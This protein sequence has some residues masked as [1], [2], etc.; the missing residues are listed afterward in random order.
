MGEKIVQQYGIAESGTNYAKFLIKK[1][2]E[3]VRINDRF[4]HRPHEEGKYPQNPFIYLICVKDIYSWMVSHANHGQQD[5]N[6]PDWNVTVAYMKE[7]GKAHLEW[8]EKLHTTWVEL[9]HTHIWRYEDALKDP[10]GALQAL[11][12]DL[13]MQA[14]LTPVVVP[15]Y[16]QSMPHENV[17][18]DRKNW[19][20]NKEY[21]E[22]FDE[23]LLELVRDNTNTAI[24][25][26]LGYEIV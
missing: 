26:Y 23:E 2:L 9:P 22:L 25:E 6:N 18:F 7:Y 24:V 12:T 4:K 13:D 11:A 19:F 1:N 3:N 17:E 15:K 14:D 10:A 16:H 5:H 8:W 20:L 21:M